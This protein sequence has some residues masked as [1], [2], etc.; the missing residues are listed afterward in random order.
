MD[1]DS[2]IQ[3]R[4]EIM[5]EE[6]QKRKRIEWHLDVPVCRILRGLKIH[7]SVINLSELWR[8]CYWLNCDSAESLCK[9]MWAMIKGRKRGFKCSI[10]HK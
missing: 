5:G 6:S 8:L 2:Q 9:T 10:N 4:I 7:L 3:K 1:V